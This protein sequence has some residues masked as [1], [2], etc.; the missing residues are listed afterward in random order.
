MKIGILTFHCA[1]N[2]GAVLQ[3]LALQNYLKNRNHDVEILNYCPNY[4]VNIYS[5]YDEYFFKSF[6]ESKST[7]F[8]LAIYNTIALNNTYK[9]KKG[10]KQFVDKYLNVSVKKLRNYDEISA[11]LKNIHYDAIVCGSDQI[12]NPSIS[13]GLDPVYFG[14]FD[15]F[16]GIKIAYAASIGK[17]A[18]E[19]LLPEYEHL[20][21]K[22]ELVS[23]RE[24]NAFD[25]LH[26][27]RNDISV[28]PD[29][30]F[31]LKK[32][33]WINMVKDNKL[34]NDYVLIYLM[35]E[36]IDAEHL[37]LK[38]A[39][40]SNKKVIKISQTKVL[41]KDRGIIYFSPCSPEQFLSLIYHADV[42]VTN[43]FH[44]VAF[45]IIYE[46][47]FYSLKHSTRNIRIENLL[48]K[49]KLTSRLI[50]GNIEKFQ[51]FDLEIIDE[52][53]TLNNLDIVNKFFEKG[54]L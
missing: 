33:I 16:K 3:A 28:V 45:S 52:K 44:A 47:E 34:Y 48:E 32:D 22:M 26:E 50:N 40:E 23:V 24:K 2:V 9:R 4:I 54:G 7:F 13:S 18:N 38:I 6:F 41:K 30:V 39:N 20:V 25:F 1:E 49:Y 29:P 21:K 19:E 42:V 43:S 46:K 31:L 12:W 53:I 15:D 36:N 8:K 17:K 37:A 5:Y 51:R 35:E 14:Y 27:V 10:F 11:Y